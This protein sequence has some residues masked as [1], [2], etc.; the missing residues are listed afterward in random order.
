MGNIIVYCNV[1]GVRRRCTLCIDNTYTCWVK[2]MIGA[3][4]FIII[5]RHKLKHN[6]RYV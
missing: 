2:V 4:S 6:V 3:K 5:K 1:S